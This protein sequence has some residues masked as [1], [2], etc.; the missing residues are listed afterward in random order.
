MKLNKNKLPNCYV[1]T[2]LM[3][4][5]NKWKVLIIKELFEGVKRFG[6][7]KKSLNNISHKVLT[8]NLREMEEDGLITRKVYP[9]IPPKV[10]YML[11]DT[12]KSLYIILGEMRKWV[13]EYTEK[14]IIKKGNEK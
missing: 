6:E 2:T 14:I 4:I 12:G 9:E 13:K 10:E 5:S 1:E 8:Y 7:L 11:T 3:L